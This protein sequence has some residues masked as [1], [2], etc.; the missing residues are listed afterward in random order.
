MNI[1]RSWYRGN[2]QCSHYEILCHREQKDPGEQQS[3]IPKQDGRRHAIT[4]RMGESIA[5]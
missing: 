5:L 2:A 4:Q 1:T 3:A